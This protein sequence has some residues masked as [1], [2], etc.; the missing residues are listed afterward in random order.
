VIAPGVIIVIGLWKLFRRPARP[1]Q[2]RPVPVKPVLKP[3]LKKVEVKPVPA[4]A[5]PTVQPGRP[6][7]VQPVVQPVRSKPM[8]RPTLADLAAMAAPPRPASVPAPA[9]P[10]WVVVSPQALEPALTRRPNPGRFDAIAA[11]AVLI[12]AGLTQAD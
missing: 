9:Q 3:V 12:S 5:A 11:A 7:P 6:G 4:A 10:R 2:W 8:L 1:A